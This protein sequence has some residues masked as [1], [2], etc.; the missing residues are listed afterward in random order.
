MMPNCDAKGCK[1]VATEYVGKVKTNSKDKNGNYWENPIYLC[2]KHAKK[3]RKMLNISMEF[4]N[5]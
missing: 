4:E 1:N 2:D 3:F 5:D